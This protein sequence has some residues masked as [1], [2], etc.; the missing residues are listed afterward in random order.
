MALLCNIFQRD[1]QSIYAINNI[2]H[3]IH[4]LWLSMC[5]DTQ[6]FHLTITNSICQSTAINA[7]SI[8]DFTDHFIVHKL[9][10]CRKIQWYNDSMNNDNNQWSTSPTCIWC[11]K[12]QWYNDNDG[13]PVIDP[14][15]WK[16]Q[17]LRRGFKQ[18]SANCNIHN[19]SNKIDIV[20]G[21]VAVPAKP[22]REEY[23]V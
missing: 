18:N 16:Q 12:V 21:V 17:Q 3:C 13:N 20:T 4:T 15:D 10:R 9:N 23:G 22:W 19:V 8:I 6:C 2:I 14:R 1:N 11:R 5:V 7:R